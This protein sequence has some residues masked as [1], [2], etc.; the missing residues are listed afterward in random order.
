MADQRHSRS[1]RRRHL[2]SRS[3]PDPV[4]SEP[5]DLAVC[6]SVHPPPVLVHE[7]VVE[8]ADEQE[9]G[10]LGLASLAPPPKVMGLGEAPG[11]TPREPALPVPV[12]DLPAEPGGGL[13][14]HP[15]D[16]Q[17]RPGP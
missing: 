9:V 7:L 5:P 17:P 4:G 8:R 2:R 16:P 10:K 14:G 11:P 3:V 12:A 15:P 6:S 1:P 13:T